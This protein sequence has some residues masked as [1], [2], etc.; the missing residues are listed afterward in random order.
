MGV[1]RRT[2]TGRDPHLRWTVSPLLALIALIS[3]P[4][5]A[6]EGR[7]V[8]RTAGRALEAFLSWTGLLRHG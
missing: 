6:I 2:W 4:R 7:P 3:I 1:R 8:L 5:L